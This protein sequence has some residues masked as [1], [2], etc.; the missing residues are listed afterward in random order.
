MTPRAATPALLVTALFSRHQGAL[1]WARGR[2]EEQ[3]GPVALAGDDYSFDQTAYYERAMGPGLRKRL[4]AFERLIDPGDLAVI[5]RQSIV[6][7][8]ELARSGQYP[9]AR[10]VNIDPGYLVLGKFLLATTK[11]Q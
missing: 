10:P 9:E 1:A 3:H 8:E 11:D 4:V 5:K 2:L 6:L 7:E